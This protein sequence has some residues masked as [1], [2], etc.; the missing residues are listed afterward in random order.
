M[1]FDVKLGHFLSVYPQ[2]GQTALLVAEGAPHQDIVDLLKAHA[3]TQ[4]SEP[5]TK[6]DL[7]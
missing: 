3:E 7:L 2:N 6:P 4:A 5:S 1:I